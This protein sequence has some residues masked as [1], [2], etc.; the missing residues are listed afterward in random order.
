MRL[1]GKIALVTGSSQGIGRAIAVRLAQEG[2][3]VAINYNRTLGG[4]QEALSE[5]E[6]AGRRGLIVQA[7]LAKTADVKRLVATAIE[8]FGRLDVL[9][10][11]AGIET[12]PFG[13]SL[14]KTTIVY[15]T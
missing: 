2:A 11:N 1:T 10:N 7:D 9:V 6:A 5:V 4:A 15:W 12:H 8:H 13:K 14:K 3:D